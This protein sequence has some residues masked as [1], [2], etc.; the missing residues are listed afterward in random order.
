M[1]YE[2]KCGAVN[3]ER[4]RQSL[5]WKTPAF[6]RLKK[7][8]MTKSQVKTTPITFFDS[9]GTVQFEFNLQNQTVNQVYFV[10]S[11]TRLSKLWVQQ[12]L[13]FVPVK[14]SSITPTLLLTKHFM[15]KAHFWIGDPAPL[16]HQIWL[17]M[18]FGFFQH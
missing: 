6:P 16:I 4:E 17:Q 7:A 5:Q 3:M 12:C 13:Y 10:E 15:A 18:E 9:M 1:K 8:R 11:S 2:M 14:Y